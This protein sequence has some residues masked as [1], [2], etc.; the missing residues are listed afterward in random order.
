M[1]NKDLSEVSA[2]VQCTL[3]RVGTRLKAEIETPSNYK[4][5]FKGKNDLVTELD[6]WAQL[7]IVK[8]LNEHF[9]DHSVLAEESS[10]DELL[11]SFSSGTW[12]VVD[13]IDGTSNFANQ[14]PYFGISAGLIIDGKRTIGLVYD[15]IKDEMFSAIRGYGSML[16][17]KKISL[18]QK[19][20]LCHA[21]VATGFPYDRVNAW[22]TW[23]DTYEFFFTR[24]RAIRRFGAATL[25]QCWVACGRFDAFFEFGLKPWDVAAGS[26][27]VEEAGGIS[28]NF[29]TPA[30][31]EFSIKGDSYLFTNK[32]LAEYMFKAPA[33]TIPTGSK[34]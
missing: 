8:D 32:T 23:R 18:A 15:P 6:L 13:P 9:P 19:T 26:L 21:V 3:R 5:N 28:A 24:C 7:E 12:W 34:H 14:I 16:N 31:G 33:G 22:D 20:E 27:I 29:S 30:T 1:T 10:N 17:G 4:I 11:R 25:D 2:I